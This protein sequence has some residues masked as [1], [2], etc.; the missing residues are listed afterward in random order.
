M[1]QTQNAD[2]TKKR[3][4]LAL[5]VLL[6]A[7]IAVIGVLAQQQSDKPAAAPE[8][9]TAAEA[10]AQRPL[11]ELARRVEG[12]PY[13]IG[14]VDAPVVIIEFADFRCHYCGVFATETFP[15]LVSEFVDSGDVRVEWHDAPVLGPG[16]VTSAT[17]AA[18]AAAQGQFWAYNEALYAA[19]PEHEQDWTRDELIAI[20][21]GI[22]AIDAEAFAAALDDPATQQGVEQRGGQA[23]SIGVTGT[24][25][26]IVGNQVLQGAQ[27]IDAFR[28]AIAA[29]LAQAKG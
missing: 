29:E 8:A 18:A 25:T 9:G 15:A 19:L 7:L 5:G 1:S 10:G 12:D 22:P 13:A 23:R 4:W 24:P 28:T 21:A 3:L 11:S 14:P 17:A 26:F 2:K 6:F 16:S 27:P 20:A